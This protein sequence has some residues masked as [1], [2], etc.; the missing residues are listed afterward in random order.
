MGYRQP[1]KM[2]RPTK[3]TAVDKEQ[4]R[5]LVLHGF[6]D[7]EVAK[8][9]G[10]T[11]QTLNNWKK[12]HPDFFEALKDWKYKADQKVV[13]ALYKRALGYR[14]KVKKA[15]VVSDGRENGSH[16]EMVEE[17]AAWAPDTAACFIWLKNRKSD[18]WKDKQEVEHSGEIKGPNIYLPK[19]DKKADG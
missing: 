2:G 18:E 16:V 5:T 14:T 17:E 10:F 3:F 7:K 8:F 11:E 1:K 15:V 6:T 13:R 12:E 4:L 9:F 19:Q